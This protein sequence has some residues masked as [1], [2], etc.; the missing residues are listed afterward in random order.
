M[1]MRWAPRLRALLA[2]LLFGFG[3]G[4]AQLADALIY[5]NHPVPASPDARLNA[6]DH[7]HSEKCDLGA[8]ITSV[9][10]VTLVSYAGRFALASRERLTPAPLDAPRTIVTIG[11]LGSRAPPVRT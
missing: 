6:G 1:M 2:I 7:C 3:G 5:H 10:P 4:G 9:P 11:A 8:P